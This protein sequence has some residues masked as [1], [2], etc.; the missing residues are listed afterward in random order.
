MI[1]VIIIISA[2]I[3]I[4]VIVIP[5]IFVIVTAIII[6]SPL[7]FPLKNGTTRVVAKDSFFAKTCVF[8]HG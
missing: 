2:I 4:I 7:E 1:I 5:I 3:I 8:P 6:I